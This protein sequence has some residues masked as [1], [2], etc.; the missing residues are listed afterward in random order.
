MQ[1]AGGLCHAHVL[2]GL[3]SLPFRLRRGEEWAMKDSA[4]P[5]MHHRDPD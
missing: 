3:W 4:P 5:L 1:W 2:H